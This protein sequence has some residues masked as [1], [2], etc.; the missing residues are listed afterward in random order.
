M[1]KKVLIVLFIIGIVIRLY[2]QFLEPTFNVDEI[3]LGRNIKELSF[4]KLLYPL[5]YGQ[6]APPLYLL[7]Q[8]LIIVSFPF[9]FWIKIKILNFACSILT[10][11]IFYKFLSKNTSHVSILMFSILIFNP[12]I[13]N[14]SLTVKQYSF[15]LLGI[16]LMITYCNNTYFKKN[17][18]IFFT[19][20][21]LISNIGL[22]GCAGFLMFNFFS[23]KNW[24]NLRHLLFWIKK[25]IKIFLAPF[26]YIIYFIWYLNQDGASELKNYMINYWS[27]SFIPLN[28]SIFKYLLYLLHQFWISFYS[29]YEVWGIILFLLITSSFMYLIRKKDILFKK[30][31]LILLC[32]FLVHVCLNILHMYPLSDRLFLY[33]APLFIL[34]LG[35]SL[36]IILN[37]FNST[38]LKA[39]VNYTISLITI[40]LFISYM[41]YK[42][43]DV[44]LLYK[45]LH[46]IKTEKIYLTNKAKKTIKSFNKFTDNEFSSALIFIPIDSKLENSNYLISR[47]HNKL[48]PNKTSKE[49]NDIASMI[50]QKKIHLIFSVAG[51]NVYRV[52][53]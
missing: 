20:W 48:K 9:A 38:K 49:E 16:I 19:V 51:Y 47:V 17:I 26:P 46:F 15:D 5:N 34:L 37:Q 23:Q 35:A 25:N 30:Q 10:L 44:S 21:C 18:W 7:L 39:T 29:A 12:F 22:F 11:F 13:I 41:P 36:D 40:T 14:N 32:V 50:H 27:N 42:D 1:T 3:S 45:K 43:N 4:H 52:A 2:F 53:K 31:I 33:L 8:K 6:S 24:L 28:S